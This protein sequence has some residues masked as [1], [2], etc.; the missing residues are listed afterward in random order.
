[1]ANTYLT[2]VD[3]SGKASE[4]SLGAHLAYTF[5]FQGG[6]ASGYNTALV[7]KSGDE[8]NISFEAIDKMAK[9]GEDVTELRKGY[10]QQVMDRLSD[11]VRSKFESYWDWIWV[12]DADFDAGNAVF[13]S[14]H[15]MFVVPFKLNGLNVE[16][17]DVAKPVVRTTD[18]EVVDG[19]VMV[20]VEFFEEVLE[21]AFEDLVKGA[22]KHQHV[23][24]YL[25]KAKTA[26][27][28]K[29]SVDAEANPA[30][31]KSANTNVIKGDT[32]LE[33][34]NKE[35]FLKS[36]EFQEVIKAQVAEAVAKAA[37]DATAAAEAAAQEQIAKAQLE[38]E[39]LRKAEAARIE[40]DYTNVV[41]SYNFVEEDKVEALVKY[42][43]D[44]VEI[45]ETVV[46][47][48]EKASAEVEAIKKEFGEERGV[49]AQNTE[50]VAKSASDLISQ[51]AAAL[52][53]AQKQ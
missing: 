7:F 26:S 5:D 1:M 23:K 43:V 18:Y 37:A 47:A 30:E 44:N 21:D 27:A 48:F 42:L 39:A 13:C 38:V 31:D 12:V 19:D 36:A 17:E 41:K 25:V 9:M 14:D 45:A 46:K 4:E 22:M 2:N 10:I 34:I 28:N 35:E 11:A 3:F 50:V 6:A 32:P 53:K 49:D 15:G 40:E 29:N 20:S 8:A 51:K 16:V 33:N 52:K 24:D